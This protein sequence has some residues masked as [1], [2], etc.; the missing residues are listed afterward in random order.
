MPALARAIQVFPITAVG[1][2]HYNGRIVAV[3]AY[4][5]G[6]LAAF[7]YPPRGGSLLSV[8]DFEMQSISWKLKATAEERDQAREEAS[9]TNLCMFPTR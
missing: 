2:T 1:S 4:T 3:N 6:R 7:V 8:S 5:V 9:L